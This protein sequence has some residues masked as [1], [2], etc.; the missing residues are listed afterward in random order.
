MGYAF[1]PAG[2][3]YP[4][5]CGIIKPHKSTKDFFLD[6]HS[7][8]HQLGKVISELKPKVTLVEWPTFFDSA[9]GRAAAG[10]GSIVKLAFGIG[11]IALMVDA[12]GGRFV[13]VNVNK[14]KGQMPKNLVI[15]RIKKR[16]TSSRLEYLL[17]ESHA[18]D[19][20]GIGLYYR[21][22]F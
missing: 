16:L 10:S 7:T 20:I 8:I 22:L 5:D 15:K 1:F 14:W 9:G 3:K 19:S 18:W 11:Q 2:K 21:G 13:P 12:Y 6:T 4:V 17:P